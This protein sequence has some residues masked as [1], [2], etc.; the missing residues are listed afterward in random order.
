MNI[1]KI[2]W[3]LNFTNAA[4]AKPEDFFRIFN[5]WIPDSPEIFIDVADYRHVQDGP[6]TLLAGYHA[7]FV[8]DHGDRELGFLYCRKSAMEGDNAQKIKQ[9]LK[10]FLKGC[11]RLTADATFGGKLAFETDSL[12]FTINDRALVPNTKESFD[13]IK[14]LLQDIGNKIYGSADLVP[15]SDSRRRFSV[16]IVG[17]NAPDLSAMIASVAK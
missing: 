4:T 17:K 16:R 5:T 2:N 9:T 1:Q 10:D 13:A 8:L 11:E 14:P 3:K 15:D 12:V 6:L 7:D